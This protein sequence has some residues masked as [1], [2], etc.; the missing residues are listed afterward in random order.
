[1]KDMDSLEDDADVDVPY[2]E[3]SESVE[4]EI[5][6]DAATQKH[7]DMLQ[8]RRKAKRDAS[9]GRSPPARKDP[10]L[11]NAT[12]RAARIVRSRA[13]KTKREN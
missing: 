5:P 2:D 3:E 4:E 7:E 10:M 12:D 8:A 9:R 6:L 13:E 11:G 1:M